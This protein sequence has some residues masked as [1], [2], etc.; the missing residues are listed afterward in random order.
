MFT[1]DLNNK[2]YHVYFKHDFSVPS[3]KLNNDKE[4]AIKGITIC[5]IY[6][7]DDKNA[8]CFVGLSYCSKNDNWEYNI[9]RKYAL[10]DALDTLENSH[11]ISHEDRKAF[12]DKYFEV[13]GRY[14]KKSRKNKTVE[15]SK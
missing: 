9:G 7:E 12:W 1:L 15:V 14:G 5:G 10:K 11:L 6:S 13:R 2:K 3:V 4:T 8:P